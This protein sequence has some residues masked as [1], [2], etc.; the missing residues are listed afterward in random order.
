MHCSPLEN[1]VTENACKV[2]TTPPSSGSFVDVT[3]I[4]W[5]LKMTKRKAKLIEDARAA[6]F[7]V[8][9]GT[10]GEWH[11]ERW[12]KHKKSRYGNGGPRLLAGMTL[13]ESGTAISK[14]CDL[15]DAIGIRSYAQMRAVLGW[16]KEEG[17]D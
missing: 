4:D 16:G 3:L 5:R 12:S 15:V 1:K 8:N 11:F 9:E 7:E 2:L 14:M 17:N 6:G 13:Y 10:Q